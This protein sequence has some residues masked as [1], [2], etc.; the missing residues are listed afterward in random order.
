MDF[1]RGNLCKH[2]Y[3]AALV[4]KDEIQKA[5]MDQPIDIDFGNKKAVIRTYKNYVVS[6][7]FNR[8]SRNR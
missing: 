1:C 5:V 3:A 2:L 7:F 8:K 6:D 4:L